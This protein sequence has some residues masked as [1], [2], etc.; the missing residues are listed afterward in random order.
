MVHVFQVSGYTSSQP[1][2]TASASLTTSTTGNC[3]FLSPL[4][5][6]GRDS[7]VRAVGQGT[8]TDC[9]SASRQVDDS[10]SCSIVGNSQANVS[11]TDMVR[12]E[13]MYSSGS[14]SLQ[15]AINGASQNFI[16]PL[17]QG[18]ITS[19][20]TVVSKNP[21]QP[22]SI[23]TDVVKDKNPPL[24]GGIISLDSGSTGIPVY[25]GTSANFFLCNTVANEHNLNVIPPNLP[26][27]VTQQTVVP[28]VLYRS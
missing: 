9:K 28:N 25:V 1:S 7:T 16:V 19:D 21:S 11:D 4:I 17:L 23:Y 6:A 5:F 12:Q 14:V 10:V 8:N 22:V 15:T 2:T 26:M 3:D 24:L 13:Q 27:M 18:Q 20:C